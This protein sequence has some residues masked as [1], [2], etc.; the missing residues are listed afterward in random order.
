MI[1]TILDICCC[2]WCKDTNFNANHNIS[3]REH[4]E[5]SVVVYGAKILILMQI[6][7]GLD[8]YHSFRSCC[9]WCKDT[10][11]NANHNYDNLYKQYTTVVVYGAKI[12]ILM[13]IT[14]PDELVNPDFMLL[15]M[16]QRY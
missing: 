9:L 11:F 5:Q 12:L 8:S 10:N 2:L 14:T 15:F 4:L 7:T 13:Q 3:L 16:V 6:T 1:A